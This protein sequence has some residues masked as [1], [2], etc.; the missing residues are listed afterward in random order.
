MLWKGRHLIGLPV[1]TQA[2]QT[3]IGEIKG[4]L[5]GIEEGKVDWL[6]LEEGGRF[7]GNKLFPWEAICS[8]TDQGAIVESE[9]AIVNTKDDGQLRD[10]CSE[11]ASYMG[12]EVYDDEGVLIGKVQDICLDPVSGKIMAIEIS[13]GAIEDLLCGRKLINFSPT[14]ELVRQEGGYIIKKALQ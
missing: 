5:Y 1:R 4:Y 11:K 7:W 10:Y 9:D 3:E 13:Q 14:E 6:L 8:L 2:S 12:L